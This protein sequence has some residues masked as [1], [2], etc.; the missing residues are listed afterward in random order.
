MELTATETS[1]SLTALMSTAWFNINSVST[2][3]TNG[4]RA[5]GFE[6]LNK[7]WNTL[8]IENYFTATLTSRPISPWMSF[9][10]DPVDISKVNI[11]TGAWQTQ[12][13]YLTLA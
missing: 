2:Y 9:S 12:G 13:F 6:I 7:S 4:N 3:G 1:T 5:I 8:Y 11:R 10:L